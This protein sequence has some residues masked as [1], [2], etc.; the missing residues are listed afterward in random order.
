VLRLAWIPA[1]A[2]MTAE[3]ER[4]PSL[5]S[6]AGLDPAIQ[7]HTLEPLWALPWMAASEGGHGVVECPSAL[8]LSLLERPSTT[9]IVLRLGWIPACA[10]MT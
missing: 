2:G 9:V 6:M 10:G 5:P 3:T 8:A 1:F 7:S 4:I